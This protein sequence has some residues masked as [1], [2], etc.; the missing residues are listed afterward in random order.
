MS[1]SCAAIVAL[2]CWLIAACQGQV[3]SVDGGT[4]GGDGGTAG[5]D[6]GTASVDGGTAGVDGG[7]ASVDGGTFPCGT[8]ACRLSADY[9]FSEEWD[10]SPKV[11]PECRPLPSGCGSCGC[12]KVDAESASM[13]CASSTAGMVCT[14]GTGPVLPDDAQRDNL[15]ITCQVP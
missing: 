9:C 7:T 11:G 8:A 12:A 6:G 13:A 10:G 1:R 3:A 14:D 2:A 5:V 15:S 4:A